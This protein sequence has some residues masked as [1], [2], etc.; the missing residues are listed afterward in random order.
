MQTEDFP[1]FIFVEQE[2]ELAQFSADWSQ[3]EAS[4]FE[5]QFPGQRWF[6][7]SGFH[8]WTPEKGV[9]IALEHCIIWNRDGSQ[10]SGPGLVPAAGPGPASAE[11]FQRRLWDIHT[12]AFCFVFNAAEAA[13]VQSLFSCTPT[14]GS[15]V[16]T[17]TVPPALSTE[18]YIFNQIYFG[19]R[20]VQMCAAVS[21]QHSS[22]WRSEQTFI[23]DNLLQSPQSKL[24]CK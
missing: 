17:R 24:I 21:H 6:T 2:A 1:G 16:Q 18:H 3:W 20:C 23:I 9:V 11:M 13:D 8:S 7:G 19:D 14:R 12:E 10:E 4:C 5:D 22:S 15:P